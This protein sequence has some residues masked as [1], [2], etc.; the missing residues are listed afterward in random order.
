MLI[1]P[2]LETAGI[3]DFDAESLSTRRGV[4]L[5][6]AGKL[7]CRNPLTPGRERDKC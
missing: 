3:A 1:G 4:V 2:E 6:A 5:F 7:F